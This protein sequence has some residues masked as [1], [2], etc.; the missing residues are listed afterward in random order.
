M[1]AAAPLPDLAEIQKRLEIIFPEGIADRGYVT[2]EVA[3]KTVFVMLYIDAIEGQ[4]VWLA[5]KHVYRFATHQV[6]QQ[7]EASR[8]AYRKECLRPKYEP[9]G[10]R[11]YFD[12]SREQI[13]DE[14]LKDGLVIKGAVVVDPSVSTT[15]SKGRYALG[16]HFARLF[17]LSESEFEEQALAWQKKYLS[18]SALAKVR[19]MQERHAVEGAVSVTMPNGERRNLATG[20]SSLIAKAVIEQFA[21]RFLRQPAV[22]WISESG[23]K[24]VVQDDRLMRNLGLPIDQQ[25]LLPDMVL[26]DLGREH[27]LLVF[28]EIV[29]SDGPITEARKEELL[30]MADAAGYERQHV[31]FVSAFEQRN[32]QP[33]KRR[34]S[35]VAIDTLIWCMAE[36]DLLIWLGENQELPFQPS[37]WGS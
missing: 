23:N 32:S 14:T 31:A 22:L 29:Y 1:F 2:R 12:N 35:G 34:L 19:I 13:R 33:L 30:K 37:E 10:T 4:S 18:A 16:T 8:R 3:A 26:A 11:W 5:P 17:L 28:V 24:V 36:P 25:R 27:T 15:S 21:P 7:D 20:G 9:G 6:E